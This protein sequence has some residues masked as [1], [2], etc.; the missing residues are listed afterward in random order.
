MLSAKWVRENIDL[1]K[2]SLAKRKLEFDLDSFL[3]WDVQRRVCIK[4]TDE[5]KPL[6]TER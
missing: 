4:K 6:Q 1:M 3:K 2:E 5:L